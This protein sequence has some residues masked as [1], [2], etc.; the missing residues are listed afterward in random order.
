[1]RGVIPPMNNNQSRYFNDGSNETM[2]PSRVPGSTS[3]K[4]LID[5]D[6]D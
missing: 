3:G 6:S 5:V 1:M 2:W 4:F